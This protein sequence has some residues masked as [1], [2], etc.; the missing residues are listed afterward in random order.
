M[1]GAIFFE[2][3][4]GDPNERAKCFAKLPPVMNPVEIVEHV[5]R[6]LR[7]E[8]RERKSAPPLYERRHRMLF[9]FNTKLAD[10]TFVPTP[11]QKE[12]IG[13]WEKEVERE[14]E[15]FRDRVAHTHRWFPAVEAASNRD[16]PVVI[17]EMQATIA[18]DPKLVRKLYSSIR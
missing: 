18:R 7:F 17:K 1:P 15:S 16:R 8:A 2:L 9:N 10:G 5:G 4:T 11:E 12:G 14:V 3:L 13:S 6:L